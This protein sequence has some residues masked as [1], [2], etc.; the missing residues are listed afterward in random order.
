M[1]YY[2]ELAVEQMRASVRAKGKD[3]RVTKKVWVQPEAEDFAEG[4][5]L[6]FDQ[7]L[8]KT[9]WAVVTCAGG[10]GVTSGGMLVPRID[11]S[12]KSFEQT[13]AKAEELGLLLDDLVGEFYWVDQVVHEMP[14]VH[15]HRTESSL[16]AAREVRRVIA[17]SLSK[18]VEAINRQAAYATI[19]GD[20]H[21]PKRVM[22][23]A[24]ERLAPTR[25]VERWNQDVS[26]A[27]G[28]ALK[29]LYDKKRAT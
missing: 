24:V 21:A 12:L 5:V 22:K 17:E 19:V 23:E 3:P 8:T 15:G 11:T 4:S 16:M 20:R 28:L 10:I 13:L 27:A 7:T 2:P 1:A 6:A 26:D 14:A 29:Y 25:H 18:T 9:G